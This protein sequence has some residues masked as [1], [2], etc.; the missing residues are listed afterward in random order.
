MCSV[1]FILHSAD[2]GFQAHDLSGTF[3]LIL[4]QRPQALF[5]IIQLD[6]GSNQLVL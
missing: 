1:T 3:L 6:L 5:R 2:L 4:L